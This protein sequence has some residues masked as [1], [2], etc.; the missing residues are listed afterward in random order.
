MPEIL[1]VQ[2]RA[3]TREAEEKLKRAQALADALGGKQTTI[4]ID[5]KSIDG[6]DKSIRVLQSDVAKLKMDSGAFNAYINGAIS[7][8]DALKGV[9]VETKKTSSLFSTLTQ[10][11]TVANLASSAITKGI[12]LLRNALREAVTEMKEMDKELTTIKMVTGASDMDIS[13][14]RQQ[15][16]AGARDTGR[17]TSDYLSA[18]ERFARAGYRENIQDLTKLSLV[19]QN[20]GGVTEDVLTA[21]H[22]LQTKTQQISE[23][24]QKHTR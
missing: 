9:Q 16:F 14:L 8:E 2:V 7:L 19:T 23:R 6:A 10:R 15:A 11:F 3:E 5:S 21:L 20:V 12:T 1:K 24:S 22:P 4:R 17:T 18:A 13:A